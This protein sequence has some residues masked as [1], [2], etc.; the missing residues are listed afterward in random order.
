L[1]AFCR[2]HAKEEAMKIAGI[3]VHKKSADAGCRRC[4]YAGGEAGAAA[5]CH[6]AER[7]ASAIAL[8]TGTAGGRS[9]DGIDRPYWRSVWLE[10]EPHMRLHL[11]QAFSNRAP[12][13]RKHDF[14]MPNV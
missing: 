12:R 3:E 5:I 2:F 8:V 14:K 1:R 13:G 11:A 7:V 4:E 6:H 10:L 9:G